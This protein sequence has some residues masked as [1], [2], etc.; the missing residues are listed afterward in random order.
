MGAAVLTTPAWGWDSSELAAR[1]RGLESTGDL[2][3]ARQSL[4]QAVR[5][6]PRDGETLALWAAFLDQRRDPEARAAYQQLLAL[7]ALN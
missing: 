3:S 2:R 1:V 5:A 6:N 4:Q 7:P